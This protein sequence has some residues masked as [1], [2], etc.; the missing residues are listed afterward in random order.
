M[1]ILCR[2]KIDVYV[3][4]WLAPV[5]GSVL[6]EDHISKWQCHYHGFIGLC[7]KEIRP[8]LKAVK[9]GSG[10][11]RMRIKMTIG[12]T[13]ICLL[14]IPTYTIPMTRDGKDGQ[15]GSFFKAS[16]QW[17]LLSATHLNILSLILMTCCSVSFYS[18][19]TGSLRVKSCLYT[20]VSLVPKPLLRDPMLPDQW[21]GWIT[22]YTK[23]WE[24]L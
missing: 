20:Q 13:E 17:S 2:A 11:V 23:T 24:S 7:L 5:L 15:V 18:W 3:A 9:S 19:G 16:L 12:T 4:S 1:L 8:D 21:W 14:E 6:Y 22:F 10:P